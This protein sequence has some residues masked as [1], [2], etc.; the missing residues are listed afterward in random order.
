MYALDRFGSACFFL[1]FASNVIATSL[2]GYKAWYVYP[3]LFSRRI[4][5]TYRVHR[6]ILK[7]LL[8][9]STLNSRALALLALLIESGIGY[10]L[11]WVCRSLMQSIHCLILSV[12]L[13]A[14]PRCHLRDLFLFPSGRQLCAPVVPLPWLRPSRCDDVFNC[15]FA[16]VSTS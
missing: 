9:K 3:Q 15:T 4:D 8:H 1:S 7:E 5:T 6:K 14:A 12:M 10:S 2:I 16:K 13:P 11:L